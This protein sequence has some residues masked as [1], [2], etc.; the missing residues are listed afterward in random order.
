MYP[1]V[2]V[3]A[4]QSGMTASSLWSVHAFI[5]SPIVTIEKGRTDIGSKKPLPG[6]ASDESIVICTILEATEDSWKGY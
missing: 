6:K 1:S 3:T 4:R 5:T 2:S